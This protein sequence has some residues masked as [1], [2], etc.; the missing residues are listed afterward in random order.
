[1]KIEKEWVRDEEGWVTYYKCAGD[2]KILWEEYDNGVQIHGNDC[3][4]FYWEPVGNGCYPDKL[5]EEICEGTDE[6][7][8]KR[9]KKI[10]EGTTIWF[11]LEKK[12]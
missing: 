4:H 11:L 7:V 8:E 6:I 3:G 1:M 5:D 2:G 9:V 12:R 10:D